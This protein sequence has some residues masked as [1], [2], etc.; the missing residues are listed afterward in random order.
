MPH[1][2]GNLIV[3]SAKHLEVH[4]HG[5]EKPILYLKDLVIEELQKILLL[6]IFL[7]EE[8]KENILLVTMKEVEILK[9]NTMNGVG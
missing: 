7:Q 3:N 1:K 6:K 4:N 9:E 8:I 2:I 5:E